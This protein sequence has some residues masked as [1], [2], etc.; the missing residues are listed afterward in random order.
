MTGRRG[1]AVQAQAESNEHNQL[2]K[3]LGLKA[4]PW[5]ALTSSVL[6]IGLVLVAMKDGDRYFGMDRDGRVIMEM[7]PLDRPRNSQA[8]VLGWATQVSMEVFTFG[9]HDYRMRQQAARR[10]FT[11][12]GWN[13]FD[14]ALESSK[15]LT[16]VKDQ[17]QV[18]SAVPKAAGVVVQ[19]GVYRGRY[20]WEVRLPMLLTF[21]QGAKAVPQAWLITYRVVQVPRTEYEEGIAIDQVIADPMPLT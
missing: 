10:H 13:G 20:F 7:H 21:Q 3:R 6:A 1:E 17:Q 2:M 5:H 14:R 12:D 19:E 15:F 16:I 4:M 18:V 8:K 9:F 11:N